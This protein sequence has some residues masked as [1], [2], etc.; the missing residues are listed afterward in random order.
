LFACV[1]SSHAF[2]WKRTTFYAESPFAGTNS[3]GAGIGSQT[4]TANNGLLKVSAWAD[5]NAS[6]PAV[7]SQWFWLLGVDSGTGNFAVVDG[8]ESMTL[9]FDNTVGA[10]LIAFMYTGGGGGTTNNL[11]RVSIE[12]FKS[13]PG[14]IA[15]TWNSPRISNFS[16]GNGTL[17]FDYLYDSGSDFGQVMFTNASASAG[18]TLKITGAASPDGDAT[19]SSV[20]LYRVDFQEAYTGPL[21]SPTTIPTDVMNAFTTPDS[22]L[23][24]KGYSDPNATTLQNFGTYQDESF[25]VKGG[26]SDGSIDSNECVTLQLANGVGL[27][28]LDVVYASDGN[29][30]SVS[31]F[32]S[33]PGLV[34]P[35]GGVL[36]SSYANGTL[37]MTIKDGALHA[38]YFSNRAASAGQ[39]LRINAAVYVALSGIGYVNAYTVLA[40]DIP[41]NISPSH[42]TPDSLLTMTGYADTPGTVPANLYELGRWLGISGGNQNDTIEGAKSLELVFAGGAGLSGLGTVYTSGQIFIS[43]FKNDPGFNDPSGIATNVNYSSGTLSYTFNAPRSPEVT[44]AFTNLSAS[45]GQT[46]S[47]HTDGNPGSKLTLTRIN[48]MP[49]MLSMTVFG[50][51]VILNWPAGTLQQSTNVDGVFN[52]VIGAVSPY[53]NAVTGPQRFFRLKVQ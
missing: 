48:Y 30:I 46:L 25:G 39:T 42:S 11:A 21:L 16:Y 20:A 18:Q 17:S 40:P 43:G 36:A 5:T 1:L 44:V 31:G 12:G 50:G 9:Q 34:D 19:G 41:S 15:V 49:T 52:D 8:T 28:R 32:L 37:T 23:T 26:L 35:S 24:I 3:N 2:P 29:D 38:F 45:I 13:N 6:V 47:M 22:W 7:L 51:D 53:T 10:A 14:P 4:L 27:S 33:N